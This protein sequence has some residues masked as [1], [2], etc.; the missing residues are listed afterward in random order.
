MKNLCILLMTTLFLFASQGSLLIKVE[1][2]NGNYNIIK[3][4]KTDKTYP[5]TISKKISLVKDDDLIIQIKDNKNKLIDYLV[6]DNLSKIKNIVKKDTKV[7]NHETLKLDKYVFIIRYPYSK[8]L[9][10]INIIK[11]KD[12]IITKK[13]KNRKLPRDINDFKIKKMSKTNSRNLD[14]KSILK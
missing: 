9:Q 7:T 13:S 10:Y 6:L 8:N 14:F 2:N 5:A 4:W 3:V 12:I 11:G 1:S